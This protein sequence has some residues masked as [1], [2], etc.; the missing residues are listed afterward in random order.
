MK[1]INKLSLI[2]TVIAGISSVILSFAVLSKM[3][4]KKYITVSE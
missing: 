4:D 3:L 1:P 2:L